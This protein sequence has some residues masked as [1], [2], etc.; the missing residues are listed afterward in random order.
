M[1]CPNCKKNVDSTTDY[2][3][4]P[5]CGYAYQ[6]SV[7]EKESIKRRILADY[8]HE[9]YVR[10]IQYAGP[11][12]NP[13]DWMLRQEYITASL[14]TNNLFTYLVSIFKKKQLVLN[15]AAK[16]RLETHSYKEYKGAAIFYQFDGGLDHG[17]F[18]CHAFKVMQYDESTGKRIKYFNEEDP[19]EEKSLSRLYQ[20]PLMGTGN[21]CLFGRH[22]R[23][24]ND[25]RPI[26]IVES[27]KSAIISAIAYPEAIWMATGS[28]YYLTEQKMDFGT[29]NVYLFPDPDVKNEVK[30]NWYK[31][32]EQEPWLKGVKV[33]YFMNKYN[34]SHG[35]PSDFDIADYIVEN[36]G[37]QSL[38]SF[39]ELL[40]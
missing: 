20:K 11:R 5:K 27:E 4:C 23:T 40:Q 29:E 33:S 6:I 2:G 7:F 31:M 37:R 32:A 22:L 16:Y 12:D 21:Y 38:V 24:V 28:C 10:S 1:E 9:D 36:Y 26:C 30:G 8:S 15:A 25:S 17:E 14:K 3:Y 19:V 39:E 35:K 34:K 13:K 18:N